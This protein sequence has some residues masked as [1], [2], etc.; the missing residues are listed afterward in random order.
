MKILMLIAAALAFMLTRIRKVLAFTDG[1]INTATFDATGT[2]PEYRNPGTRQWGTKMANNAAAAYRLGG[3]SLFINNEGITGG[4]TVSYDTDR[5]YRNSYVFWLGN[6]NT[7]SSKYAIP[8]T[9]NDSAYVRPA[10]MQI[11]T[12]YQDLSSGSGLQ[13]RARNPADG[14][15]IQIKS[16]YGVGVIYYLMG[17]LVEMRLVTGA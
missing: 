5:D 9:E 1:N 14:G 12:T 17:I 8:Y 6:A 15:G 10:W 7:S 13:I 4:D 2:I 16:N 11:T 3:R